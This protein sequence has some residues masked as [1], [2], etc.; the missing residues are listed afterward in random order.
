MPSPDSDRAPADVDWT[1]LDKTKFV[2]YGAGIF[3]SVT[4]VLF[5]LSVIK[6]RQMAIESAAPGLSGSAKMARQI[7]QADGLRGFYR[8]FGT[9][10]F[11]AIPARG[12]YLTT[13]E[14]ARS[15]SAKMAH[16]VTSSE[17]Q[18]AGLSNFVA[19]ATA[20]CVT[21]TIVVPI[22]VISQR[23]MVAEGARSAASQGAPGSAL[24]PNQRSGFKV[25]SHILKT[26][27]IFG[28]YR[29]FG[30]SLFTFVP[31]SAVW[32][33]AYGAYQKLVWREVERWGG[34]LES[35]VA[36]DSRGVEG[37]SQGKATA[38]VMAVQTSSA[39][40]SG[41]TAATL[42]NP[43]D[44]IKTRLQVAERKAGGAKPSFSA[45][46]RKLIADEGARGLLKGVAPRMASTALWGTC[47]VSAYEFLKRLCALPEPE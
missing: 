2:V 27:G 22:D 11:G 43:L 32:W 42:T 16:R 41:L 38:Q 36:Q 46:A 29:G 25:I 12:I 28:L 35:N 10:V 39:L 33:S 24:G 3:S 30:A 18:A 1:R 8:G 20:S 37:R 40:L 34:P 15:G 44:V 14:A 4:T 5:P 7:W 6:T 13:L 45:I 26:D 19:G 9:I 23:Q 31:S 47:M 21:Q 17:A